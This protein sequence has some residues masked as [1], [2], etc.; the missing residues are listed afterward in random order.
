MRLFLL[1]VLTMVAFAANSV[2]NRIA[3]SGDWIGP[4]SFA[5]MRL[6]AGAL[7]LGLVLRLRTGKSSSGTKS[8]MAVFGL[9]A[10][11]VGFSFAYI[12]LETGIGWC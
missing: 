12:W 6:G 9:L 8:W 4:A 1:V 3:L 5:A 2:L 10:Y 11:M 7:V